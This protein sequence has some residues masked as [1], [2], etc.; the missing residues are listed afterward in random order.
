MDS[1]KQ[2]P[3]KSNIVTN[4][5]S[6]LQAIQSKDFGKHYILSKIL[7]LHHRLTVSGLIV[8]FLWVPSHCGIIG[9]ETADSSTKFVFDQTMNN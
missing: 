6:V 2:A 4:A 7:L 8:H 1:S 9:N 3:E 5:C